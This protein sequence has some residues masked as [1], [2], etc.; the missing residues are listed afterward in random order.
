[1]EFKV[2]EFSGL[3][4]MNNPGAKPVHSRL[5]CSTIHE[6]GDYL[7]RGDYFQRFRHEHRLLGVGYASGARFPNDSGSLR[8]KANLKI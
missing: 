6:G 3:G 1:M 5:P 8:A 4:Q 7:H 2:T